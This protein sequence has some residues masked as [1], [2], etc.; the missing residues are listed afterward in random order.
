MKILLIIAVLVLLIFALI[1]YLNTKQKQLKIPPQRLDDLQQHPNYKFINDLKDIMARNET[2][3]GK[4]PGANGEFGYDAIN[5]IPTK[6]I[7]GSIAYLAMLRTENGVKVEYERKGH[8]RAEN[9]NHP[10][11]RY[12]I[13]ENG[14]YVCILH[15]CPYYKENSAIVQKGFEFVGVNEL[16]GK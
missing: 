9:V 1:P 8:T 16:F 4:I 6:G 11:D 3:D 7:P 10:I 15:L 2:E 13:R 5:P 14:E 12:E